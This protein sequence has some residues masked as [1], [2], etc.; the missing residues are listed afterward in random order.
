[1]EEILERWTTYEGHFPAGI[2]PPP[3]K[4]TLVQ[5]FLAYYG[6]GN[7]KPGA[8]A[9][10]ELAFT[11]PSDGTCG[12]FRLGPHDIPGAF[13][14]GEVRDG[15][16]HGKHSG[17]LNLKITPLDTGMVDSTV[18]DRQ[19]YTA[20]QDAVTATAKLD[21]IQA[22]RRSG[23]KLLHAS[24]I[25]GWI[26]L[27]KGEGVTYR[28][29]GIPENTTFDFKVGNY[30]A[31]IWATYD[32]MTV[33]MAPHDPDDAFQLEYSLMHMGSSLSI[34]NRFPTAELAL[35]GVEK[36]PFAKLQQV[37]NFPEYVQR[38]F[39]AAEA[40]YFSVKYNNVT[41]AI[42]AIV[43]LLKAPIDSNHEVL[44]PYF[45]GV[46]GDEPAIRPIHIT[47]PNSLSTVDDEGRVANYMIDDGTLQELM[48]EI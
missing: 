45:Y 14:Q 32:S 8:T 38:K 7:I 36:E 19:R 35:D 26:H 9:D 17:D 41:D 28:T 47:G 15:I 3:P 39:V 1:M 5:R 2:L 30:R 37:R 23:E 12:N 6:F 42:P 20:A 33:S 40:R 43:A 4:M 22:L 10:Q 27:D 48:P 13:V 31:S 29:Y 44:T 34:A 25:E 16:G 21:M 18:A 46:G 24:G 11:P